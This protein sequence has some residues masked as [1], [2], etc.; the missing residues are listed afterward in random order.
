MTTEDMAM[1]VAAGFEPMGLPIYIKGHVPD[2]LPIEENGRITILPKNDG[3]GNIFRKCFV[4]VNAA[5]PDV[6]NEKNP[7]LDNIERRLKEIALNERVGKLN[8]EWYRISFDHIGTERDKALECHY[9]HI[10]L[11][12]ETLNVQQ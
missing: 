3:K 6:H 7:A 10:Q 1:A 12:F 2:G 4:E 9:V 5:M 11:L 8:G